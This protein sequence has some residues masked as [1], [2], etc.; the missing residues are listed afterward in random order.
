[1]VVAVANERVERGEG[2]SSSV[3]MQGTL[4]SGSSYCSLCAVCL[5]SQWPA[6]VFITH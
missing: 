1:M 5:H 6:F 4:S 2:E 3:A